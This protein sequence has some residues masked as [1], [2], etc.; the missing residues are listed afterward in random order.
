M[1]DYDLCYAQ[2]QICSKN[3]EFKFYF[4]TKSSACQAIKARRQKGGETIYRNYGAYVIK[5]T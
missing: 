3:K 1:F 4:N 5:N 2:D